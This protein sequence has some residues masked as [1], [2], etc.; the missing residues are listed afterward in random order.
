MV[1]GEGYLKQMI[2]SQMGKVKSGQRLKAKSKQRGV[3][4]PFVI[5]NHPKLKKT[6]FIMK[7]MKTY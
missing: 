7:I 2:D 4:A 3:D 1:F 6:K 5:P